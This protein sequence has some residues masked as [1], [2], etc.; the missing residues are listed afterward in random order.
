MVSEENRGGL[1]ITVPLYFLMLAGAAF[2]AYR[3]NENINHK[4]T[5]DKVRSKRYVSYNINHTKSYKIIQMPHVIMNFFSFNQLQ[6]TAHYL[7]GRDF[8]PLLTAGT[9]FASL[10]RYVIYC[11]IW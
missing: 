7:A 8:G 4:G 6:L 9:V 3:R 11:P 1:Y 10:F 2:W 5:S